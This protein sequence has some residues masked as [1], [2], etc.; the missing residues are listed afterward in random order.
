MT[1]KYL[2]RREA[3]AYLSGRGLPTSHTTLAK[4]ATVGGGPEYQRFGRRAVYVA[5]ALDAWA[6]GRLSKPMRSTSEAA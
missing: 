2:T 4:L 3:S 5:E 6:A 1:T